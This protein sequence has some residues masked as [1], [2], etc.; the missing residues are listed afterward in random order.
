MAESS[1]LPQVLPSPEQAKPG[2]W[3][4]LKRNFP[5]ARGHWRQAL[6]F[7]LVWAGLLSAHA[8]AKLLWLGWQ[9]TTSITQ[10]SL[11]I[12]VGNLLGGT[13]AWMT[14]I[15]IGAH[16]ISPKRFAVAMVIILVV[17]IG[18]SAFLFAMQYRLYYSQWHMSMFSIG[19]FFQL[20]FTGASALYLFAVQ[21]LRLLLPLGPLFL[22]IAALAF[23][24]WAPTRK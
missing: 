6:L 2:I 1:G 15:T 9:D 13:L 18:T 4:N 7:G 21:G 24:K 22:A 5:L 12:F 14:A 17:S 10:M 8:F 23:V 3:S 20:V 16:R 19:W 11:L